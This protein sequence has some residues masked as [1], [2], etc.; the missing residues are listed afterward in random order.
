[1]TVFMLE[2][3]CCGLGSVGSATFWLGQIRSWKFM[4]RSDPEKL[5]RIRDQIL[6]FWHET[7]YNFFKITVYLK[8]VRFVAYP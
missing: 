3:Q 1:M 6:H 7:L 4:A 8:M 2:I 5:F